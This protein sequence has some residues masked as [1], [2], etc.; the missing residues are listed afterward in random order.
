MT[1]QP[2]DRDVAFAR[3]K[4]KRTLPISV[5]VLLAVVAMYLPLPQRF[6]AVLPLALALVQSVRLLRFLR[7]RAGR[8]R[9]WPVVTLLLVTLL[10]T[11]LAG[12]AAFYDTIKAYEQCIETAQTSA[13]AGDCE[14]LRQKGPLRDTGFLLG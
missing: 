10:L 7:H 11:N 5:L 14:Q 3:E 6:V 8:E 13:A 12:Q 9:L 4:A 2:R 1:L